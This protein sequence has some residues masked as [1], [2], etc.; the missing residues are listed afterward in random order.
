MNETYCIY[1]LIKSVFKKKKTTF[2]CPSFSVL[3]VEVILQIH[4]K[5]A[6]YR[7]VIEIPQK[8][9]IDNINKIIIKSQR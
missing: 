5:G 7:R 9:N 4:L 6:P 3:S 8:A 1:A 2:L